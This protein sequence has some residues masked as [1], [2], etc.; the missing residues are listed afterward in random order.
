MSPIT[1]ALWRHV[2]YIRHKRNKGVEAENT[3]SLTLQ[4]LGDYTEMCRR[5][6]CNER[7]TFTCL[8]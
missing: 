6:N 7:L 3:T 2:N 8:T 4:L 5:V 1:F